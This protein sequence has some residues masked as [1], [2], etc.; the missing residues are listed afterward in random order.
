MKV[1]Q[2]MDEQ[3]GALVAILVAGAIALI[4]ILGILSSMKVT[5]RMHKGFSLE[6]DFVQ[7]KNLIQQIVNDETACTQV[8]KSINLVS[9]ASPGPKV[10]LPTSGIRF[11]GKTVVPIVPTTT[12]SPGGL[13]VREI[14]FTN[15]TP[16]AGTKYRVNLHIEATKD[17]AGTKRSLGFLQ[18]ADFPIMVEVVGT[19]INRCFGENSPEQNCLD[20]GATWTPGP[21]SKCTLK[22]VLPP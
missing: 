8:F 20:M 4:V 10:S 22:A 15:R 18:K 5:T 13:T 2:G 1:S 17:E 14:A 21:P 11:G 3:G 19:V 9:L 6:D 12:P 7:L 16:F